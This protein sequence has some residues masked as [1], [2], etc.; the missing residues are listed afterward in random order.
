MDIIK[1]AIKNDDTQDVKKQKMN[2][3]KLR[4]EI[5]MKTRSKIK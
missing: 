3:L 1:F 5:H 4:I 2:E